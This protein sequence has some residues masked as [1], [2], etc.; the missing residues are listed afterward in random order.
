MLSVKIDKIAY[1]KTQKHIQKKI[2]SLNKFW[3]IV[4]LYLLKATD[5][6]FKLEGAR[7]GHTKWKEFSLNTLFESKGKYNLRSPEESGGKRYSATSLLLQNTGQLRGSFHTLKSTNKYM[8]FGSNI[9]EK[10]KHQFG[11]SSQN[12]PARP[13]LFITAGDRK[14]ILGKWSF[15]NK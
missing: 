12:L 2:K 8:K 15:F 14:K 9:Q 11:D 5:E 4:E 7:D 1:D 10:L 3:K 13:M 6:T